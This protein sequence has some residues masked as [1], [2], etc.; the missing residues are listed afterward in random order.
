[1][2]LDALILQS[3][4]F[5]NGDMGINIEDVKTDEVD[6]N[7]LQLKDYTSMVGTGGSLNILIVITYQQSL[8][9]YLMEQFLEGEEVSE[10]ERQDYLDSVS[11]EV[12]NT[13]IGLALPT[14]PNRGKG[15]TITPPIMI[16]D[17]SH[18]TK[19]KNSEIISANIVTDQGEMSI[20]AV[21]PVDI[22]K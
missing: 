7:K 4:L 19:N 22:I 12:I 14:F 8:L 3:K 9:D 10:D 21:G 13:I 18:I 5:L 1:M 11:G 20:G 15:V 17:A 6:I 2:I 16:N